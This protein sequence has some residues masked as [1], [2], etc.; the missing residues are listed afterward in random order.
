MA[1]MISMLTLAGISIGVLFLVYFVSSFPLYL[2]LKMLGSDAGILTVMG[3]NLGLAGIGFLLSM[4]T[5]AFYGIGLAA[6]TLIAYTLFFQ[7]GFL[8][9][10]FAWILQ[11]V[12]IFLLIA[13]FTGG[14]LFAR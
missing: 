8:R 13:L 5:P 14:V 10:V 11:Y 2:A 4:F 6:I 9:A 7:I 12:V 3:V 1:D